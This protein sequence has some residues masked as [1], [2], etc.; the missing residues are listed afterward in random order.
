M[1]FGDTFNPGGGLQQDAGQWTPTWSAITNVTI[2]TTFPGMFMRLGNVVLFSLLVTVSA[3]AIGQMTFRASL[4][5]PS[6]FTNAN[7]DAQ[8][9]AV[10]QRTS[11]A[12]Q[13]VGAV[14]A[15]TATD[16]LNVLA[17]ADAAATNISFRIVG[18]YIIK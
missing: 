6:A 15:F 1:M 18:A 4:P 3:T 13:C 8:G 12:T 16:L 11:Q 7:Q 5:I 17:N 10:S 14:S 9:V 2:V